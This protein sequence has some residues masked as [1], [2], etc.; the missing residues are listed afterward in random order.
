MALV[1]AGV[2]MV[3]LAIITLRDILNSTQKK[4]LIKPLYYATGITGGLCLLI[5][6]LG[7]SLFDFTAAGDANYPQWLLSAFIEDRQSML[8]GDAWRSFLLITLTAGGIW[9]YLNDKLKASYLTAVVGLLVL[10]DMWTVDKRF[11]NDDHFMP[12]QVAKAIKPTQND[13]LILQDKDPD[14]RV[15]NLST[16]TF[17]ESTTSYFHK[18]VGGY[19][20]VKLRRYQ[21]IIDFYLSNRGINMN[22]LNM[23]NTKYVIVPT[24]QGSAVQQNPG[25]LGNAWFV[26]SLRWVDTPDDEIH[27]LAAFNPAKTAV[28]DKV[29]KENVR[30]ASVVS[31]DSA[32]ITLTNYTPGKL[33]YV[34]LSDKDRVA[35]FSEVF[36][37]T[38]RAS[39]DGKEVNPIR[40]NY[41]LRGLEI[42]AGQHEVVFECVDE[43][44]LKSA[45]I[46]TFGSILVGLIGLTLISLL[47]VA[48]LRKNK[49]GIQKE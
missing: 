24:E 30:V 13:L 47:I 27:A 19:S 20:P 9:L 12:K 35:V 41:I 22:V 44:Y 42:P 29:W 2:T 40:V 17:N 18:S 21:D 38:W 34:S 28:I 33:T 3:T 48:G 16:N 14:Y 25:A 23:L 37:K 45:K 5:A 49:K 1:I 46:S 8:T 39:I 7:K 11:L 6:L 31:G 36:Y 10:I 4:A 32:S 15:L 43:L 26:D